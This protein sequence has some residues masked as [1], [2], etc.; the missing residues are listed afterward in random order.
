MN[1]TKLSTNRD[2]EGRRWLHVEVGRQESYRRYDNIDGN[3]YSAVFFF[4]QKA[5]IAERIW[6]EE[7]N[8][9]LLYNIKTK[10][11]LK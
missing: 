8:L 6:L 4:A 9:L 11:I 7:E 5:S 10:K 3:N 1:C 2:L